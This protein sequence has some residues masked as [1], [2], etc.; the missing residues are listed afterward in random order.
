MIMKKVLSAVMALVV[1]SSFIP[2]NFLQADEISDI[3]SST[4]G[5]DVP[6]LTASTDSLGLYKDV[7]DKYYGNISNGWEDF[8]DAN[9]V[10]EKSDFL[11]LDSVSSLWRNSGLSLE[12]TGYQL[13]DIDNDGVSEL[14]VAAINS[15]A[16]IVYDVYTIYNDEVIHLD[17]SVEGVYSLY[18]GENEIEER[19]TD[20]EQHR[21]YNI[22]DGGLNLFEEYYYD[23][24]EGLE[25]PYFHRYFDEAEGDFVG[26]PVAQED[27][28][29][30]I[31]SHVVQSLELTTFAEYGETESDISYVHDKTTETLTITGTGKCSLESLGLSDEDLAELKDKVKVI[32]FEGEGITEI[33][34]NGF[35]D[36]KSLT[37]VLDLPATL[38]K[39]GDGAFRNCPN[40]KMITIPQGVE[41]IGEF[42]FGVETR[43]DDTAPSVV[44]GFTI[45][46]YTGSKAEEYVTKFNTESAKDTFANWN[47]IIFSPIPVDE[48]VPVTPPATPVPSGNGKC[49]ETVDW[50]FDP[51]TGILTISGT[52][53]MYLYTMD[54]ST[55]VPWNEFIPYIK[56]IQVEEGVTSVSLGD[57]TNYPLLEDYVIASTVVSIYDGIVDAPLPENAFMPDR[58]RRT[59]YGYT[60]TTDAEG[61][62]SNE[63]NKSAPVQYAEDHNMRFYP[64]NGQ[65]EYHAVCDPLKI[66]RTRYIMIDGMPYI[67]DEIPYIVDGI[68]YVD[69][70][71]L[72]YSLYT[73][74]TSESHNLTFNL[75]LRNVG[76]YDLD[77]VWFAMVL[78][79]GVSLLE[80]AVPDPEGDYKVERRGNTYYVSLE[81][82]IID[83]ET[84]EYL[85]RHN[86]TKEFHLYLS[87]SYL[88]TYVANIDTDVEE[89]SEELQK[90]LNIYITAGAEDQENIDEETKN[91]VN[92]LPTPSENERRLQI[93]DETT[94]NELTADDIFRF[95]NWD[96]DYFNSKEEGNAYYNQ[97][98]D[99]TNVYFDEDKNYIFADDEKDEHQVADEP[100]RRL[101]ADD[102][103]GYGFDNV[104]KAFITKE[105]EDHWTGS[106]H[107]MATLVPLVKVG[108]FNLANWDFGTERVS[109]LDLPKND[110]MVE[111]LVNFYDLQQYLPTSINRKRSLS[112]NES[113]FNKRLRIVWQ[114]QSVRTGGT[115]VRIEFSCDDG[116][117]SVVA[118]HCDYFNENDEFVSGASA[119]DFDHYRI[120][121]YDPS[122][123]TAGDFEPTYLYIDKYF[124]SCRYDNRS[125]TTTVDR[126]H[127]VSYSDYFRNFL[128]EDDRFDDLNLV[129][130]SGEKS[131]FSSYSYNVNFLAYKVNEDK[132]I[133]ITTSYGDADIYKSGEG[134]GNLYTYSV[135]INGASI[136][137]EGEDTPCDTYLAYFDDSFYSEDVTLTVDE[138][139]ACDYSMVY[140]DCLVTAAGSKVSQV[141]LK[142]D[143]ALALTA[144]KSTFDVSLT[145]NEGYYTLP[146]YTVKASGDSASAVSMM[147]AGNGNNG[148]ILNSDNMKDVIV[149]A[150]N[151]DEKQQVKFSTGN[152]SV[153][154]SNKDAE[155]AI[156]VDND[157]DG[158]Y[159]T[160][161]K[162]A[163]Q[164]SQDELKP[165][166]NT[167]QNS[168]GGSQGGSGGSSG[169]TS[170]GSSGGETSAP[171]TGDNG[172][173]PLVALV[174]AMLAMWGFKKR[175]KNHED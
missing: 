143:G 157:H 49:G 38:Q 95:R 69:V 20:P 104:A 115:P 162:T 71:G 43:E 22:V 161:L 65:V 83:P 77:K 8:D 19:S 128:D 135:P 122:H 13:T 168:G 127:D 111:D 117:R 70:D 99:G 6:V 144:D 48:P 81:R 171:S 55:V 145:F 113:D 75:N 61:N 156:Y 31:G 175:K 160:L 35:A 98:T 137:L 154:I 133:R 15:E 28:E 66:E 124:S 110:E 40:L 16:A 12:E 148:I 129:D 150:N 121:V 170:G 57:T 116:A 54:S 80:D 169:G 32:K 86:W 59:I 158:I 141:D 166:N 134:N 152:N 53:E 79:E 132:A 29:G 4:V 50:S 45:W 155:L 30:G 100:L 73:A 42:A 142:H 1:A 68:P 93:V 153:L 44:E 5:T 26:V 21:Y 10:A 72:Q 139:D 96:R 76:I 149:S 90:A 14:I 131:D 101:L 119:E 146:W 47:D 87:D 11:S 130:Y 102:D 23:G 25:S 105:H 120:S 63:G 67:T 36:M 85:T 140:N 27:Y 2:N 174:P 106:R 125:F 114:T 74:Y 78:P 33:D 58:G 164:T 118:Y 60:Y 51:Q 9:Y 147:K 62:V 17:S 88:D 37:S 41:E 173:K 123:T 82:P 39:I 112:K 107:G 34:A 163:S 172:V 89:L 97:D 7:L 108:A 103:N 3:T 64:L 56:R 52:N 91:I 167:S 24:T 109:D 136:D 151:L 92:P 126:I 138:A 18:V 94:N 165:S 159:E 46:G 84:G